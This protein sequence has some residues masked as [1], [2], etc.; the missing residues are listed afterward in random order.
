[1]LIAA[2]FAVFTVSSC[3]SAAENHADHESTQAQAA[4]SDHNADDVSFAKMM[5]PHHQQAVDMSKM[6][7][8]R[9]TDPAVIQLAS[10]IDAAQGP[11]ID[12][13]KDMLRQWGESSDSGHSGHGAMMS[14]MVDDATMT[15][16]ESLRGRDFDTLWLQSMI[17]HHQGAVEMAKAEIAHGRSAD[18]KAL[19]QRIVTAQEAEIAQMKQLLGGG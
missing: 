1:M 9:S 3:S 16:L 18:A 19:A 12:Q 14:G 2:L 17:G 10:T 13:M 5:I 7:P 6:V 8:D 15:R 4:P 11:E